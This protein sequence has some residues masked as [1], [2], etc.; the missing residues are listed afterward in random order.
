METEEKLNNIRKSDLQLKLDKIYRRARTLKDEVLHKWVDN[1]SRLAM[2]P[3][4]RTEAL[5]R[6][7]YIERVLL[8]R[9]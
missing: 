6:I 9:V 7:E 8:K 3:Q 4:H 1:L 2:H 5:V